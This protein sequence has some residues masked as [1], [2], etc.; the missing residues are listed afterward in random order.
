MAKLTEA[1]DL[2]ELRRQT[3]GICIGII[4]CAWWVGAT[5][6]QVALIRLPATLFLG[7]SITFDA[8]GW[9]RRIVRA[10]L[11]DRDNG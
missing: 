11:E 7:A 8:I 1:R 3:E 5:S 2:T 6:E 10:I 9:L 4:L